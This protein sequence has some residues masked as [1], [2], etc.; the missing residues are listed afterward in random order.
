MAKCNRCGVD[1]FVWRQSKKGNW[2]MADP[3]TI[4]TKTYGKYITIPF[5][6]KCEEN[7]NYQAGFGGTFGRNE[8]WMFDNSSRSGA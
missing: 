2:Y 4:S 7:S 1:G 3:K 8:S 5:A 6:H